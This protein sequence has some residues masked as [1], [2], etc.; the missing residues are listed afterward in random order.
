MRDRIR[1]DVRALVERR[2]ELSELEAYVRAPMSDD[3]RDEILS[4]ID[5]FTRRYPTPGERLAAAR[6]ATSNALRLQGVARR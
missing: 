1:E 5:W 3:E 4:L 2:L 6:R